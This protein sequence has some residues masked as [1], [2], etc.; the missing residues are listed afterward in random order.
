MERLV[1]AG[2][3]NTQCKEARVSSLD[4]G[5]HTHI[6]I[7]STCMSH[8]RVHNTQLP[9]KVGLSHA[10]VHNTQ[11]LME[12]DLRGEMEFPSGRGVVS[13]WK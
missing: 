2:E 3:R 13:T 7:H 9:M 4:P 10:H 5:T 12:V 8:A 11:I 1:G 6:Y